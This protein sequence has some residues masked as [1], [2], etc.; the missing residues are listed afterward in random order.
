VVGD[1]APWVTRFM[2]IDMATLIERDSLLIL[3]G[4]ARQMAGELSRRRDALGISY[5]SVNA[6]FMEQF[7]PVIELLAGR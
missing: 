6:A 4:S 2:Q 1:E 5:M 3:R 7:C